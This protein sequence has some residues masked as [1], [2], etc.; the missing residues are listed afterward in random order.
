MS[1]CS[2]CL[3]EIKR[4]CKLNC[5]NHQFCFG[6][7]RQWTKKNN[8]CP[9][10]RAEIGSITSTGK[11]KRVVEVKKPMNSRSRMIDHL[12]Q[13][14]D[15]NVLRLTAVH[16]TRHTIRIIPRSEQRD[17]DI[18]N[19][20]Q[21]LG[22]FPYFLTVGYRRVTRRRRRVRPRNDQAG[23]AEDPILVD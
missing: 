2:I 23:T 7:I 11:R 18:T 22:R 10:C 6:C 13:V 1:D 3:N 21:L 5:C 20:E 19:M 8:T 4:T 14:F 15:S 16:G 9:L 12:T 17:T